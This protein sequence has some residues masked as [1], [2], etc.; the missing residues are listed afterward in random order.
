[1]TKGRCIMGSK[2]AKFEK[3]AAKRKISGIAKFLKSKD[4]ETR[5][6]AI[7]GLGQCGGEDAINLLTN[8]SY[9]LD[10][11]E[12]ETAIR[13]LGNCGKG[14]SVT[15]MSEQ[16]QQETDPAVREAL[17]ESIALIRSRIQEKD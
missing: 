15:H 3:L 13:A 5:L 10:P 4:V 11:K 14:Y 17:K 6:D 7:Y 1:M 8:W 9:S 2:R 12:R 16:L